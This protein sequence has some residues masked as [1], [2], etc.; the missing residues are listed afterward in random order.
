[1]SQHLNEQPLVFTDWFWRV[2]TSF[3]QVPRLMRWHGLWLSGLEAVLTDALDSQLVPG[4]VDLLS[5][6]QIGVAPPKS[7]DVHDCLQGCGWWGWSWIKR[8][9]PIFSQVHGRQVCYWGQRWAWFLLGLWTGR[10]MTEPWIS[11]AGAEST[12]PWGYF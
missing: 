11:K 5:W 9:L 8:L 6:I 4:S 7:L 1:M 12:E 10:V 3:Y 2:K